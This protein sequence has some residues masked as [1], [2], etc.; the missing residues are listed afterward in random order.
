MFVCFVL[1]FK[2][3]GL[4]VMF[5]DLVFGDNCRLSGMVL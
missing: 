5:M 3:I 2:Q 4:V 1:M